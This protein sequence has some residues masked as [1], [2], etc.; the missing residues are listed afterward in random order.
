MAIVIDSIAEAVL[1]INQ[2]WVSCRSLLQDEASIFTVVTDD[3]A[4]T[5]SRNIRIGR[6]PSP[7]ACSRPILFADILRA[8]VRVE[9]CQPRMSRAW[10]CS[11]PARLA[12]RWS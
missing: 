3:R 11:Q 7:F 8:R 2:S 1:Y 6:V 10:S 12:K 9:L 4:V 5:E